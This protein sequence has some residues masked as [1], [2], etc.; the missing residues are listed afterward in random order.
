M[1]E[2]NCT[3]NK[4]LRTLAVDIDTTLGVLRSIQEH[5][6]EL[7]LSWRNSPSVSTNMYTTH[8]ISLTEH[9]A[10]WERTKKR[11]DQQYFVYEFCANAVGVVS[12]NDISEVNNN[13]AW[14][15]YAD[16]SAPKGAGSKMEWL[17]LE[18]A[19]RSK[20]LHKLHCEVL[21]FNSPVIK[22]HQKF[23]FTVEGILRE[24][25]H[26]D[27]GYLDVYKLGI[28]CREWEARRLEML[29]RIIQL[30]NR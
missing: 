19:F 6:L 2:S 4:W 7:I 11:T 3:F 14:A 30:S 13:S 21:A 28:F 26:R 20:K 23:G 27:S 10:W 12:F 25:Y 5:D 29:S 16:P 8:E 15:F 18:Y 17:A 9:K 1:R 22:L 24:H